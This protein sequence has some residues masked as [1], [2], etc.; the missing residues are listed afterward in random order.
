M[1]ENHEAV[2][3]IRTVEVAIRE[4]R[5]A[6]QSG[7]YTAQVIE[8]AARKYLSRAP[9]SACSRTVGDES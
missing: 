4:Y 5:A 3:M 9:A 6:R 7:L 1:N 2:Q 8:H